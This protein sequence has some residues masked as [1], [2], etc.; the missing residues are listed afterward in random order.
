MQ[1]RRCRLSTRHV[2]SGGAGRHRGPGVSDRIGRLQHRI[3]CAAPAAAR[4]HQHRPGSRSPGQPEPGRDQGQRRRGTHRDDR[5]PAH[6]DAR[7]PRRRLDERVGAVRGPQRLDL[8]R[9]R[10]GHPDQHLRPRAAELGCRIHRP[11]IRLH[12]HAI[13]L[14][15]RSGGLRRKLERGAGGCRP[16]AGVGRQLAVLLRSPACGRKPVSKCSRSPPTP[17]PRNS[18]PKGYG[19]RVWFGEAVDHLHPRSVQR[20]HPLLPVPACPSCPTR[21]RSPNWPPD[22]FR[23]FP[24]CACTTALCTG[25]TG[26]STTLRRAPA[27]AAGEPGVAGRPDRH[28]HAG[29]FGLLLRHVAQPVRGGRPALDQA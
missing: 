2:E 12:Q 9:A 29:Q 19:R 6:A 11:R 17:G 5:H 15:G 13:A 23:S 25:G 20:E 10:R 27:S 26:P 8:Q 14:A 24:N 4:A 1:P 21:I 18:R 28:R 22:A 7:T 16:S 3:Q